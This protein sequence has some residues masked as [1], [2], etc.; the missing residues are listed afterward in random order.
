LQWLGAGT[1]HW[2]EDTMSH[3]KISAAARQRMTETGESYAAAR[4]AV[5][6]EHQAAGGHP[7]NG[8]RTS[9]PGQ[10]W[11]T[12][13][14]SDAWSGRLSDS[15]D[16]LLFRAGR[17]VSGVAVD[18]GEI[19]VRMGSFKLDIPRSSVRS[20]QRSQARVGGTTGV[21][22][23]RGRWL[24]NGSAEGL[25]ELTID[26]PGRISPSID[27]LYGLGP[28]RVRQLTLSLD[29][30]DGFVAAVKALLPAS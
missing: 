18:T 6:R 14:Y 12:I 17:G 16:R 9:P 15:L 24:V 25:A 7:A 27:T 3:D 8:E 21:H 22:G 5:I 1:G 2:I 28:S 4:R 23:R 13:S 26:P 19:R 30:P 29:D 11:F 10:Q 20:V